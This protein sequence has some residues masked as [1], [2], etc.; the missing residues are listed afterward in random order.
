MSVASGPTRIDLVLGPSAAEGGEEPRW[1]SYAEEVLDHWRLPYRTVAVGEVE[2]EGATLL[3]FP[4]P[5]RLTDIDRDRVERALRAGTQ[6]VVVG[7]PGALADMA[8]CRAAGDRSGGVVVGAHASLWPRSVQ[9]LR[10]FAGVALA[11]SGADVV[12]RWA[13]GAA[14]MTV[15]SAGAGRI[16]VIGLDLWQTIV[17]IQQ[18]WPVERDGTPARDG[19]APVDEGILKTDDGIALSYEE[20]RSLPPGG[21]PAAHYDHARPPRPVPL[22]DRPQAD[23]WREVLLRTLVALAADRGRVLPWLFYWPAGAPAVVHISNDSDGNRDDDA[24]AII[25]VWDEGGIRGTFCYLYPGGLGRATLAR[26]RA[27][28]HELAL[29]HDALTGGEDRSWGRERLLL[30]ADWLRRE[31][32]MDRI[33][34]NKNHFLRWEGWDDFYLW[35]EEAGIEVDQ[36]HGPSKQGNVGFPFGSCHLSFPLTAAAGGRRSSVLSLPLLTQDLA[37]TTP[38]G[39]AEVLLAGALAHHGVAHLLFHGVHIR[40]KPEVRQALRRTIRRGRELGLPFWTSEQLNAW[41]RARRGVRLAASHTGAGWRLEVESDVQLW[42]A[43]LLLPAVGV[44][45]GARVA[46][47]PDHAA[48]RLVDRHGIGHVEIAADLPA[49]SSTFDVTLS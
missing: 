20:D 12:A 14:A 17:R 40:T 43:C 3:L 42:G 37:L 11:G 34:S 29:H 44:E 5:P 15:R 49:G 24:A 21:I 1:R 48:A 39:T 47:S 10:A 19:S 7:G 45:G 25:D 32:G 30:Q 4:S 9:R 36:S 13:D 22:F 33:V 35:C 26:I 28:G 46:V 2:P 8:G 16:A 41:E 38:A 23:A 27:E 6:V 18:G 31:A